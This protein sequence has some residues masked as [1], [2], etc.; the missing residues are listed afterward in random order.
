VP[1]ELWR[2]TEADALLARALD[3]DIGALVVSVWFVA[4]IAA[5]A[6]FVVLSDGAPRFSGPKGGEARTATWLA[7]LLT[8]TAATSTG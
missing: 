4:A 2:P 5:E 3:A 6:G 8:A 7:L 1:R